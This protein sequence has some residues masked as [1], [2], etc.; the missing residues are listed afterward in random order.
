[1]LQNGRIYTVDS[2]NAIVEA[3]AVRDGHVID[4]GTTA[5]LKHWIGKTTTVMDLHGQAMYPGFKDSHAH[6][7]SVGMEQIIVNLDRR[8][9]L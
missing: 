2:R 5:D 4:V 6:L 7:L 3:V 1:M 8:A 9:R